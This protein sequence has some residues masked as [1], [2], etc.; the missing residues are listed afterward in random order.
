MCV[1]E[2]EKRERGRERGSGCLLDTEIENLSKARKKKIKEEEKGQCVRL[3]CCSLFLFHFLFL[4]IIFDEFLGYKL[5]LLAFGRSL[6]L[7][8]L[9]LPSPLSLWILIFA[10]MHRFLDDKK[11]INGFVYC[12]LLFN[13][14]IFVVSAIL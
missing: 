1:C 10:Y 11:N 12:C 7:S 6:S 5:L 8:S 2:R 4:P 9:P 3:S 13:C 14:F